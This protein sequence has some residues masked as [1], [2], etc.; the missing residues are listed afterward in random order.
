MVYIENLLLRVAK[1]NDALHTRMKLL[2]NVE[3]SLRK[4]YPVEYLEQ[5]VTAHTIE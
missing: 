4:T 5:V 3:E 1:L 2:G